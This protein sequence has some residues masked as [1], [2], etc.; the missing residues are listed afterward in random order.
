MRSRRGTNISFRVIVTFSTPVTLTDIPI[1][2]E[3]S[4]FQVLDDSL[5]SFD[6]A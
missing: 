6:F 1:T 5:F 2:R 4:S 3:P